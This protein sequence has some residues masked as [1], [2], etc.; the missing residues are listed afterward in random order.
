MTKLIIQVPCYNEAESLPATLRDLPRQLP[1]VSTVE[2]LVIDDG[3]TDETAHVAIANGVDHVVRHPSNLGLARAFATGL[4][5]CV[6]LG[7]DIVVNTDA[8]NQYNALDIPRL[9]TPILDGTADLVVG[10]RPIASLRHFSFTK[11]LLQ[12][13]GSYVVRLAS[14]TRVPDAPSG[15]RAMSR[16][17]AMQLH[18]LSNHTYTLETIIQAGQRGLTVASV[19]IRV[20]P[21]VRPSRLISSTS[22]YVVKSALTIL[23]IFLTYRP[24]LAFAAPGVAALLAGAALGARFLIYYAAGQ[25]QGHIQSLILT[26]I[27]LVSGGL[28]IVLGFLADLISVNRRL[29]E[30]IDLQLHE[31]TSPVH[32]DG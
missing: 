13:A 14:G 15:F 3:S 1:G 10:E 5:Q 12:R 31:M 28:L 8:D 21:S 25:G 32:R 4:D 29:L 11:R 24:L 2:W 7:A 22:G 23:R 17:T 30:R 27:L 16:R 19:P 26:A 6:R 20:N 18:V 9:I